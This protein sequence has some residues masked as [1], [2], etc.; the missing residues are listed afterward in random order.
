M[1]LIE[2]SV[3]CPLCRDA[4]K[5]TGDGTEDDRGKCYEEVCKDIPGCK[6]TYA[7]LLI[8]GSNWLS[9]TITTNECICRATIPKAMSAQR[10]AI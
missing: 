1:D 9:R 8:T 7:D 6:I 5:C 4:K 10:T 3:K 2:V